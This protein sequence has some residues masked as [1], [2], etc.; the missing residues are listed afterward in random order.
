MSTSSSRSA[1]GATSW[2]GS[3][4]LAR[5]SRRRNYHVKITAQLQSHLHTMVHCKAQ[6]TL[7]SANP[8]TSRSL[9]LGCVQ[10]K[11]KRADESGGHMNYIRACL[12]MPS[13][14]GGAAHAPPPTTDHPLPATWPNI[15]RHMQHAQGGKNTW[16]LI[17]GILGTCGHP[18]NF[19]RHADAHGHEARHFHART[20]QYRRGTITCAT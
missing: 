9:S 19:L 8:S 18:L 17:K 13:Y 20:F 4:L 12:Q 7:L 3:G 10:T 15:Q 14:S 6:P 5:P 16:P 11:K 2:S 1:W